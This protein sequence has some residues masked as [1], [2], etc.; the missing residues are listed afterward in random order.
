[1]DDGNNVTADGRI[2]LTGVWINQIGDAAFLEGNSVIYFLGNVNQTI[3]T[4]LGLESFSGIHLDNSL[5]LKLF[6]A[7]NVYGNFQ[8]VNGIVTASDTIN[9]IITFKDNATVTG[10]SSSSF[11][12]RFDIRAASACSIKDSRRLF[13]LIS[14][15]FSRSVSVGA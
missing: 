11:T 6:N 9:D 15:A 10:A 8:M 13:C 2:Y 12:R 1:M 5:G 4:S 3:S 14:G 7:I